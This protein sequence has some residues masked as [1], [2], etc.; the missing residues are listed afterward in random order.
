MAAPAEVSLHLPGPLRAYC[1][2]ASTLTLRAA[3]VSEALEEIQRDREALYRNIC[4]ETGRL[5]RHLNLFV[6]SDHMRDLDGMETRLAAGD[7]LTVLPAV[8]GG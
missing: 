7:V 6:N 8:S 2:G 3:T 1:G 4:D 5:R